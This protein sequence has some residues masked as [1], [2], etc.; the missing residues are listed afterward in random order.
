MPRSFRLSSVTL[1]LIVFLCGGFVMIFEIIGSRILSPFIGTS[2]YVWTS[3]IG[4]ILAS[5][6]TG[7][8]IGGR[9]ADKKP[10]IRILASV[11]FFAGGLVAVTVLVKDVALSFIASAPVRSEL[12]AV[13]ASL[14]LF[15][16]ASIC[17]G[18]VTPYAV[19]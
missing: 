2:T 9:M 10:D 7:Y 15:A 19:R 17:L 3:L 4:V 18:I 13:M 6:S 5:L 16:P 14:I 12:Q 1:E 8:W 11:I